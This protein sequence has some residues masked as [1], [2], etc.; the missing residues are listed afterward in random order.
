MGTNPTI[1][2]LTSQLNG[3]AAK[4][5]GK[6][7]RFSADAHAQYQNRIQ[8]HLAILREEHD[9]AAATLPHFGDVGNLRSAKQT[10]SNLANDASAFVNTLQQYIDYVDKLGTAVT[11]AYNR[12]QAYDFAGPSPGQEWFTLPPSAQV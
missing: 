3:F 12:L 8:S 6:D 7:T 2:G 9:R 4:G 11:N 10:K 5:A 1:G